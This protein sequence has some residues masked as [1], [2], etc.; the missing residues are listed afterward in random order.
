MAKLLYRLNQVEEDEAQEVR[1]LLGA[2]NIA[3]YETSQGRWRI[4]LAAIWLTN[5]EDYAQARALLDQY[6]IERRQR[7]QELY[8]NAPS[9]WQNAAQQP[10]RVALMLIALAVIL[11]FFILPF[12]ALR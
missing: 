5:E 1:D 9:F 8:A 11:G 12:F 7:I 10:V 3:F 2:A 4:S 6:Q